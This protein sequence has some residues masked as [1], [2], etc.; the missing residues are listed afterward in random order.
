MRLWECPFW[1]EQRSPS[2]RDHACRSAA[3]W[4]TCCFWCNRC[5]KVGLNDLYFCKNIVNKVQKNLGKNKHKI[6]LLNRRVEMKRK[7]RLKETVQPK[8]KLMLSALKNIPHILHIS[9]Q[10]LTECTEC[11]VW[12]VKWAVKIC[13]SVEVSPLALRSHQNPIAHTLKSIFQNHE[14]KCNLPYWPNIWKK[15]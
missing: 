3:F 13:L 12:I 15:K 6:F 10:C 14:W 9:I 8:M 5:L 1:S 11:P 4:D 7:P 2:L